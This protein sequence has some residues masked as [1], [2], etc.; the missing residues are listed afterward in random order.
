MSTQNTFKTAL[1]LGALTGF[2]MLMGSLIGGTGGMIFALV[3]A[4]I[5]NMGAWWFSASLAL[6]FSGA[7]EVSPED[8]PELHRMVEHLAQN[9][10]MPKPKVYLIQSDMPNAFATGRNPQNG[11]VAVTTGIMHLLTY[12]ELAGV[13]AHELAHIKNYDTLISSIAAT[14]GG[15][16]SMI[17]DM[18]FWGMLF[19]GGDD[20]DNPGGIIG[21]FLMMILAPIIALIIQMAI[22]R[23]RE[24]V[25]DADGAK[26]QGNPLMLARA[27][28]KIEQWS[29]Q[30]M[31]MGVQPQVNPATSHLYIINPLKGGMADL[32]RT[33]PRT[34]ERIARL[35]AMV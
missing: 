33:H 18:A 23:A 2:F 6:R 35:E 29:A 8:A 9:A 14:F 21:G 20:E 30:Q 28:R 24:F 15:A 11:A 19:G 34:E 13:M 12:D 25:A 26:I 32:F 27:L 7:Q 10:N 5:M 16:I 17:A 31:H 3:L 4:I 1:L 22:S